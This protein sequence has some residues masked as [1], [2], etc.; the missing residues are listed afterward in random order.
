MVDHDVSLRH[1]ELSYRVT[2]SAHRWFRPYFNGRTHYVRLVSADSSTVCLLCGV[3]QG[4]VLG[5]I[6]FVLYTA[7]LVHLVGQHG[8]QAHL[9]A[10]D[11]QVFETCSP[12]DVNILKSRLLPCL[13]DITSWM[14][15]NR[16][17]L[18]IDNAE[19]LWCATAHYQGQLL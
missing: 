10:D 1:I 17:Q 13:D 7:D 5:P 19:L 15:S 16:L 6:L 12:N 2:A 8:L 11:T 18:N 9:Y 14:Q 4:S 3:P